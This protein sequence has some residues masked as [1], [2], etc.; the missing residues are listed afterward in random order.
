MEAVKNNRKKFFGNVETFF[1][2]KGGKRYI[3][4]DYKNQTF[5]RR[6]ENDFRWLVARKMG[7]DGLSHRK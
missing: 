4:Q 7:L 5:A 1:A 2:F 6:T 3:E